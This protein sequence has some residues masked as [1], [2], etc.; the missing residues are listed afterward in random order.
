QAAGDV[1][2]TAIKNVQLAEELRRVANT[3]SLT[4]V[5]N[6]RYFHIA[7]VHE[8]SRAKRFEKQ[9]SIIMF[10]LQN[11]RQVNQTHGFD[12]GDDLL[13][14]VGHLLA[15]TVRGID[16]VCRYSADRFAL[17]LPETR[18]RKSVV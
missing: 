5:Y 11:F 6:Q 17:I 14:A 7:V 18:D 12:A 16:T 3:D 15:S 8:I 9:F 4:G 2:A 1:C 13:R 10:D